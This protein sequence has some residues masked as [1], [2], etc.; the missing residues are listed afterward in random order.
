MPDDI[1]IVRATITSL[2]PPTDEAGQPLESLTGPPPD[3]VDVAI[4][5]R[6]TTSSTLFVWSTVSRFGY[7]NATRALTIHLADPGSLETPEFKPIVVHPQLPTQT[8]VLAG[9]TATVHVAIPQ[10]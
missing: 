3:Q 5:V 7:D 9:E 10:V 6:N 1:E 2:P 8:A 4:E